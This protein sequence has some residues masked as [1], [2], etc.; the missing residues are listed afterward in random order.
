MN[1]KNIII[2]IIILLIVSLG[3]VG[4]S[5]AKYK[6]QLLGKTITIN[7]K[8]YQQITATLTKANEDNTFSITV[9]NPNDYPINYKI[10]EKN[11]LYNVKYGETSEKYA[12]VEPQS[13]STIKVVISGREDVVYEDMITDAEGNLYKNID[14][15]IYSEAPYKDS[16]IEIASNQQ[17]YLEKSIKNRIVA[18]AGEIT[19]Y[20]EGY[21][22]TGTSDQDENQGGLCSIVDPVSGNMIYFFRGNVNNN[23]VSF[24]GKTWRVL[25]INSDGSLRLILDG[26]ISTCSYQSTNEPSNHTIEDAIELIDWQNSI[27]Y[28]ELQTWY[29]NNLKTNYSEYIVRSNYVFDTSYSSTTSSATA[30]ACYYFGPYLRVGF[31]ANTYRPTF[32]YTDDSLW[33]DYIGLITADELLY[34]GAYFGSNNT[35]YFLH[36]S[37]LSNDF[38]TMSP[39]FWDNSAHY[40]AGMIIVDSNGRM[41]DWPYGGNTLTASLALRPVISIRGDLEM[42][43]N[44][45]ASNPYQ[46][47][48]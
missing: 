1:K 30:A 45:T 8:P 37:A 5:Y 17:I 35:T 40:K 25:R 31:D 39:S 11:D 16:K 46:Y 41:N 21:T 33:K 24:A 2:F 32:S 29:N 6:K 48:K 47:S 43:G 42:T 26:E 14:I 36:N 4:N 23:Y 20:Q 27:P 15:V 44:G 38:W 19:G 34:A 22:F 3:F 10:E 28:S 9:N 12:T 13:T 7:S 18:L